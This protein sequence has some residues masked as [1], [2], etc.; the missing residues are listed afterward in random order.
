VNLLDL[1]ETVELRGKYSFH[2]FKTPNP[3]TIQVHIVNRD[4]KPAV[5]NDQREL[6]EQ[7]GTP[8]EDMDSAIK[9]G[10]IIPLIK[11]FNLVILPFEIRDKEIIR[12]RIDKKDS[13]H[14]ITL[15]E[16]V[17]VIRALDL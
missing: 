11:G 7:L 2:L 17:T 4:N 14:D 16:A 6:L 8:P 1:K 15:E 5:E 10:W 9:K 3:H 13:D 12:A